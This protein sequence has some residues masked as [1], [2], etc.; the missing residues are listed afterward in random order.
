MNVIVIS[1]VVSVVV[2]IVAGAFIDAKGGF[3]IN[4]AVG[5]IYG[6][7]IGDV[8]FPVNIHQGPSSYPVSGPSRSSQGIILG[9][10]HVDRYACTRVYAVVFGFVGG[11]EKGETLT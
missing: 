7:S 5:A 3:I 1:E 4:W 9:L 6:S 11:F 2:V 10:V 8:M